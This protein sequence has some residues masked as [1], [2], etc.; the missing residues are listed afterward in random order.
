MPTNEIIKQLDSTVDTKVLDD[1]EWTALWQTYNIGVAVANLLNGVSHCETVTVSRPYT[2][3]E[4]GEAVAKDKNWAKRGLSR[5]NL[6]K[7][8]SLTNDHTWEQLKAALKKAGLNPSLRNA[9]TVVGKSNGSGKAS[10]S[11]SISQAQL[12]SA[13]EDG[14]ITQAQ[15]DALVKRAK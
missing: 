6:S 15:M 13:V 5:S 7:F 8:K 14:I 12:K 9:M 2:L 11:V 3:A 1:A 4:I 10:K